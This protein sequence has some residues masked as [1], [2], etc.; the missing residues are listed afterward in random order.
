MVLA[1]G[2]ALAAKALPAASKPIVFGQAIVLKSKVM[3]EPRTINVW[4]PPSYAKNKQAY[5]VL[6]VIDG[7]LEQDFL[8][9]TGTAQLGMIWGRNV[10]AIIVGIETKDRRKELVGPTQDAELLK[11]YPTAGKSELFRRFIREEVKPVVA[12]QFRTSGQTAVIGESLAGLFIVET[13]LDEPVVFDGYAAIS[14]SLWWDR[15]ALSR[16]AT[17]L[18]ADRMGKQPRLYL[19]IANEGAEMQAGV[20]RLV[21]VLRPVADWCYAPRPDLT[22]ATIYQQSEAAAI[23]FLLPSPYAKETEGFEIK[24]ANRAVK[25]GDGD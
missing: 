23:Q 22:H 21:G 20:D 12:R 8:H 16:K 24:C 15:E 11:K 9:V 19:N 13:W 18:P 14:P 17:E 2:S 4:L 10:E 1:W 5:P 25:A 3:A 7:G 6:Y